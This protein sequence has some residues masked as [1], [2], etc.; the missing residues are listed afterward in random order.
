VTGPAAAPAGDVVATIRA[1]REAFTS[2]DPHRY[3]PYL[4]DE[5]TYHAGITMRR[6]RAAFRLNTEA[7]RVLYPYGALRTAERRLVVEGDWV[8]ALIDREAVTNADA[9]YENV[10]AMFYE[11]RGGL[12]ATQVEL[13]DFNVSTEKFDLAALGP[14]LRVPGEQA[15]PVARAEMPAASD[16]SPSAAA[17]RVVLE[18]LDAFLRFDPDAFESLLIGDPIHRV[19][20]TR[21][22]G[23]DAFREVA[24]M[25][26]ILYPHG[27]GGRVHHVLVSDGSTVATLVSLR[28]ETNRGVAYENLYGMFFDVHEGRIA[29]MVDVLDGRVAAGAF[30]L[31]ALR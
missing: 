10:Y 3:E 16:R 22:T 28:A 21:R 29:S 11:L 12:V 17:K 13:M 5:P 15:I 14:D 26:R 2:F 20:M 9:Y 30:D 1:Y 8:A 4:A 7:G 24:R 6:G 18:F 23:R 31:D 25:G 27:I 19:G